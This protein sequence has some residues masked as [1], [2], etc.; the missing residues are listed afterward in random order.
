[1]KDLMIDWVAEHQYEHEDGTWSRMDDHGEAIG[2]RYATEEELEQAL[3]NYLM[4]NPEAY[5]PMW[6]R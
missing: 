5:L 1:M 3:W 4:E 2:P 6:N